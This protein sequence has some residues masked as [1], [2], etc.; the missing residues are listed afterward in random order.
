MLYKSQTTYQDKYYKNAFSMFLCYCFDYFQFLYKMWLAAGRTRD[1]F[2][3]LCL[4]LEP[5]C[6]F[7]RCLLFFFIRGVWFSRET[8]TL[9]TLFIAR[10]S[11][12][13]VTSTSCVNT[14]S[15]S[16]TLILPARSPAR[17]RFSASLRL[18]LGARS[19][20]RSLVVVTKVN[21]VPS[22]GLR[23]PVPVD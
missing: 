5:E 18:L 10:A 23:R 9:R 2:F 14:S 20:G 7:F 22:T 15:A 1:C 11:T 16:P 13:L 3:A 12:R 4:L 21:F 8:V 19:I 17:L 6:F